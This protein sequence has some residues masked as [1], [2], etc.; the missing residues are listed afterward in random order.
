MAVPIRCA[1]RNPGAGRAS[2]TFREQGLICFLLALRAAKPK[3]GGDVICARSQS[4]SGAQPGWEQAPL[5]SLRRQADDWC[6]SCLRPRG[7]VSAEG[8]PDG[9]G[10]ETFPCFLS[11]RSPLADNPCFNSDICCRIHLWASFILGYLSMYFSRHL[12]MNLSLGAR[13]CVEFLSQ[14]WDSAA[15]ISL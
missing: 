15:K 2:L 12:Y 5:S 13:V 1:W 8:S 7:S 4:T 14:K 6:R 11:L 10:R 3:Q 9:T